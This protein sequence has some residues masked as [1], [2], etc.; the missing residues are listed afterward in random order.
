MAQ[1]RS[2]AKHPDS[3]DLNSAP[4]SRHGS[5]MSD[6]GKHDKTKP[7]ERSFVSWIGTGLRCVGG[8]IGLQAVL[9]ACEMTWLPKSVFAR[10]SLSVIATGL[11]LWQS[12]Q[13]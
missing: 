6:T 9:S 13:R 11:V 10:A 2:A 1:N 12:E 7:A 3:S 8:V 5:P 4:F